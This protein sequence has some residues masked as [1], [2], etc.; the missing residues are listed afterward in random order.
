MIGLF[1]IQAIGFE[2]AAVIAPHQIECR[3]KLPN[4]LGP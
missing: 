2:Q 1:L 3:L 4:C